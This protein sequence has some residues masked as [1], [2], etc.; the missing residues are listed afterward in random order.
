VVGSA[1]A[2]PLVLEAQD[3]MYAM[4]VDVGRPDGDAGKR[5]LAGLETVLGSPQGGVTNEVVEK[6]YQSFVSQ[7]EAR[8]PVTWDYKSAEIEISGY[9]EQIFEGL[10]TLADMKASGFDTVTFNFHC[11]R[12]QAI[13]KSAP[14]YYPWERHLGCELGFNILE[15]SSQEALKIYI[16]EAKKLGLR[17]NL[18]PMFLDLTSESQRFG[19]EYGKVPVDKFLHGDAPNW[20]GYVPRILR[21]AALGEKFGVEYLTIGTEF[22][23]L[24]RKMMLLE[25]WQEIIEGIRGVYSGKLMYSHNFGG[26]GTVDELEKMKSFISSIDILGINYFPPLVMDGATHY[27]VEQA[28]SGLEGY[29]TDGKVL[30]DFLADFSTKVP[31]K[32]VMSEVSFPTW[33]GSINWMFRHTCD[34][35]NSGKGGWE[36]TK[37][38]LAP[39]QPSMS[40]SLVLAAAWY[41]VFADE[42]WVYG[43]SHVFWHSTWVQSDANED[44]VVASGIRECGKSLH[45]NEHLRNVMASYYR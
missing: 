26:D 39:K 31:A 5:T 10:K 8:Q 17:V 42:P 35:E 9:N 27:T 2:D 44:F 19:Y 6:L 33:R 23:N 4:S 41:D 13:D 22:G 36:F 16:T 37:G 14:E 21:I 12:G 45:E 11:D 15:G 7:H 34:G 24:N 3:I 28:A 18:K 1:Y 30:T 43:A 32:I 29:R 40:A 20:D 38:P 25:D